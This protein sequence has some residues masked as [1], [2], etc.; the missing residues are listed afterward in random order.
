MTNLNDFEQLAFFIY[1]NLIEKKE[2]Q[3]I[4]FV[5]F[6]FCFLQILYAISSEK[7]LDK[8]SASVKTFLLTLNKYI[9][10]MIC[11]KR[12]MCKFI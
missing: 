8:L 4:K 11:M 10:I 1:I 7:G 6:G 12:L 9:M 3:Q 5:N 2:R